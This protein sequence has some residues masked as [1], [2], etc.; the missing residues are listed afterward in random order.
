MKLLIFLWIVYTSCLLGTVYF[1]SK[2]IYILEENGFTIS[3]FASYI[4]VINKFSLNNNQKR[5]KK[6][7]PKRM[8]L[9]ITVAYMSYYLSV[10]ISLTV[11]LF[12]IFNF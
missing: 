10:I 8:R 7:R 3:K 5:I 2:M 6:L 12:I 4:T 11:I 9:F 1:R